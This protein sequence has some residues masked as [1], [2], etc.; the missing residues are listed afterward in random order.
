MPI[1]S[2][3]FLWLI[4]SCFRLVRRA[5]RGSPTRTGARHGGRASSGSAARRPSRSPSADGRS[6]VVRLRTAGHRRRQIRS[7][8]RCRRVAGR[9]SPRTCDQAQ[10]DSTSPSSSGIAG[11]TGWMS[12]GNQKWLLGMP[13]LV[14]NTCSG[15]IDLMPMPDTG[16]NA[17]PACARGTTPLARV[18]HADRS[19]CGCNGPR[20]ARF[21]WGLS[22][23][24]SGRLPGDSRFIAV[25]CADS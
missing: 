9:R 10:Y 21:Y 18:Y 8:R 23:R 25:A 5:A 15:S 17:Q 19:T 20:P 14:L 11:A 2:I 6:A 12:S 3:S 7:R 1:A 22:T 16:T 24:S 4:P 13:R